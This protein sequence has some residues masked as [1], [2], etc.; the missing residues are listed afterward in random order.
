MRDGPN[1]ARIAA[2]IGEPARAE[3]LTALMADRA[4]TAT[5]LAA[6]AGVTKQTASAHLA[7]L[8]DAGLVAVE[9][10]GRHR[11][12]RLAGPDVAQLLESLMGVAFR[13]GAVRLRSSPREPALRRARVCY[14]H[15]AGAL[16]VAAFD[17]MVR[18]GL[19]RTGDG[20]AAPTEAGQAWFAAFGIDVAA[21]ASGRRAC[22]RPCLD[23]G[24]RRHH[25]A[26]ALGA[27]FL[28]R[29]FALGWA[30]RA[31][32]SRVVVFTPRGEQAFLA[33]I[34]SREAV[35]A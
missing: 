29:I 12:F 33:L 4:L 16:G 1:I 5:E 22:C 26:G 20:G 6:V 13:T 3:V 31:P 32:D 11:Y 24:E 14:D 23:W 30:A 10:Q 15:L 21:L 27:A 34:G 25:L 7:K 2:L 8:L 18:Q 17:A 28:Q 35:A 19:L 9:S